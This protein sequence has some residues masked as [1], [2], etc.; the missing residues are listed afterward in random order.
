MYALSERL[1]SV[2]GVAVAIIAGPL[3]AAYGEAF[4]ARDHH[5]VSRVL[6]MSTIRLGVGATALSATILLF[7]KPFVAVLSAGQL[8]VPISLAVA[9][10]IWRIV[11]AVGQALSRL[12]VRQPS[13]AIRIDHRG[14]NRVGLAVPK[15]GVGRANWG[16][17]NSCINVRRVSSTLSFPCPVLCVAESA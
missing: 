14:R 3:W 2:V 17:R 4:G 9:M 5:W 6:R 15:G 13:G 1:F 11:E 8:S 16:V 10:A 7:M 12:F